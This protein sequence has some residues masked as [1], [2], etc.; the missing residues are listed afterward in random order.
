MARGSIVS[1]LLLLLLL[2]IHLSRLHH[3][4]GL[5]LEAIPFIDGWVDYLD[6]TSTHRYL[7]GKSKPPA[8]NIQ[9]CRDANEVY[10]ASYLINKEHLLYQ[11]TDYNLTWVNCE[12]GSF[13]MMYRKGPENGTLLQTVDVL[14]LSVIHLSAYERLQRR[15]GRSI[16]NTKPKDWN[17]D[18]VIRSKDLLKNRTLLLRSDP[19]NSPHDS[20]AL[21]YLN[22]TVVIMPFLG[23]DNGAGHS[24]LS[25]RFQYVAACFWAFY[26]EYNHIVAVVKSPKDRDFLRNISGLPFFDVLLIEGLPKSASLPVSTVQQT[27][28]RIIN[29]TWDFDYIFFTESDQILMMRNPVPLYQYIDEN[30]RHLI[31]PH[32]LMPYP[33]MILTQFY[34]RELNHPP[35]GPMTW[36]DMACC[37]PRQ[38][39][40]ERNNWKH[41]KTT[42]VPILD[43]FGLQ[44]PLGNA[45]FH[46]EEYRYCKLDEYWNMDF[47]CP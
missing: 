3:C 31:I 32:R 5:E 18:E 10:S 6:L 35:T 36:Q 34:K 29:G 14:D 43:I 15:W 42:D 11:F 20:M 7:K 33:Q 25:N 1:T 38:N 8:L 39:C 13:I 22:R 9:R 27:K 16:K 17:I 46:K 30:P 44:V 23:V 21:S 12:M 4:S 37:M 26:A 40:W 47:K 19:K 45:N 28:E 41:V 2:T 24:K